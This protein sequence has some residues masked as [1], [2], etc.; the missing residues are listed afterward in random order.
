[1]SNCYIEYSLYALCSFSYI[2]YY[3]K[4]YIIY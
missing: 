4:Y 3:N 2:K 1:M